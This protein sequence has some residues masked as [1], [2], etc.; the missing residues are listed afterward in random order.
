MEQYR[1]NFDER[2]LSYSSLK[3]FQKSPQHFVRYMTEK[4]QPTPAMEFGNMVDCLILTP[5]EFDK[6]FV[7]IPE[8][9]KKPSIT[10]INAKNPSDETIIQVQKWNAWAEENKGKKWVSADDIAEAK[11]LAEKTF[12]NE[13]AAELLSR[14][15][16]TQHKIEWRDPE[17]FLPMVG[18]I[19][20]VGDT[21]IADLKTASS[22]DP[23]TFAR[24]AYDMGYHIQ[25]GAYLEAMK[26]K[27]GMFPDFYFIVVETTA[28]NNITIY[29]ADKDF[30]EL[31]IEQYKY[32]LLEIKM[33]DETDQWHKG[34]EFHTPTGYFQLS[35]PGWAARKL[36]KYK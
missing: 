17:T 26:I 20:A 7:S 21:F 11:M 14:V 28:P 22:G 16:S 23:E 36:E 1:H 12:K 24:Q 30:I 8:G 29:K 32:L 3:A 34:Y 27:R 18:Y 19:D 6:K 10:Q 13:K 25:C 35:L 2:P 31:G 9:L 15:V 33:C 5:D 4:K